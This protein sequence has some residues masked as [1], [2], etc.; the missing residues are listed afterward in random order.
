MT[1]DEV[2]EHI[3]EAFPDAKVERWDDRTIVVK[4]KDGTEYAI[5]VTNL[6]AR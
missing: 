1:F 4:G 2:M 6:A 5:Q 3:R